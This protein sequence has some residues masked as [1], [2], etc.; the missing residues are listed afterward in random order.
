MKLFR[1]VGPYLMLASSICAADDCATLLPTLE[2]SATQEPNNINALL[3]LGVNRFR[4]GM[5][6][7]ALEP[8]RKVAELAPAN[9][10][11]YFYLGVSLLALDRDEEAKNAFRR[12]AALSP[13]DTDQ[14]FILQKGYSRL[15]AALLERMTEAAPDSAR[16][17]QMRAELL[18][19]D[20]QSDRALQEYKQAVSKDPNLSALHYAL[21]CAYYARFRPAE[22]IP[23][24][25]SAIRLDSTHYM[26]HFKLGLALIE[27]NRPTDAIQHLKTSVHLQPGLANAHLALAKAYSHIGD[28]ESALAAVG[29]CL[30]LDP[31][32]ESAQYLRAQLLHK[33]G[34]EREANEQL[35]NL[36]SIREKAKEN[37]Q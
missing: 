16:V 8:L 27:L 29:E 2:H 37:H 1:I 4:C 21:G 14:L 33:L 17:H 22:A 5:P 18:D 25:E 12:M 9:S 28:S 34:R 23:E 31:P 26:A 35:S 3:N 24:F 11:S 32:N 7:S 6:A 36:R 13:G 20:H 15:A 19:L 10:T 30:K